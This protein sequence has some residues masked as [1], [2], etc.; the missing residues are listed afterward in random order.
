MEQRKRDEETRYQEF[1][2]IIKEAVEEIT[3]KRKG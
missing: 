3:G 2:E 1:I